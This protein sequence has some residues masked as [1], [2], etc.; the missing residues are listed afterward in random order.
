MHF[1]R[2]AW[3]AVAWLAAC[4]V[5]TPPLG[6]AADAG[7]TDL[8]AA[9][10]CEACLGQGGAWQEALCRPTCEI[11][12]T[13][14]YTEACPAPCGPESCGSCTSQSTCENAGCAWNQAE[15]A[16]WCRDA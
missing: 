11:Q 4:S 3:L 1:N 10:T 15:E 7:S 13:S 5:G 16:M 12:D 6:S 2:F 8:G 9:L 14:C